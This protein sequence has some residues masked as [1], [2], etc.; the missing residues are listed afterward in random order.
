MKPF[1]HYFGQIR[2]TPLH[3]Q[4]RRLRWIVFPAVLILA[5]IHQSVLYLI[6]GAFPS[7]WQWWLQLLIYTLTGS[8]AAWLGLTWI[9]DAAAQRFETESQLRQAYA[10]LEQNHEKLLALHNLGERVASADDQHAILEIAARAPLELTAARASTV[11]TFDE[12]RDR[13]KLDMAWGLSE[14][15]LQALRNQLEIGIPAGR[16]QHCTGLKAHSESDCPLFRGLQST[17]RDEGIQSLICMPFTHDEERIGIISAYFPSADGPPEDQ[18]RLLNILGRV[19]ATALENLRAR[20]RELETVHALDRATNGSLLLDESPA[21]D[22]MAAQVLQI[23]VSGWD[24]QV[25]GLLLWEAET[26]TWDCITSLGFEVDS[27]DPCFSVALEMAQ[28][29]YQANHPVIRSGLGEATPAE[30]RSMAA[31]PLIIEGQ[32][33]GALFLGAWRRRAINE[34]QTE[35][36]NTIAHQI[37]LAIRNA[38]LYTQLG[39]LAVLKE[40]YRLSR[41]FHDGLAQTL[42]YLGF[43]ADRVENLVADDESDEA[44][45]EIHEL[46][47]TIRAA[48]ADV[49]EAIDGLRLS[50]EDPGQIA[51]RLESYTAAYARQTGINTEFRSEPPE[52]E[53]DPGTALQILRIAQEALTNVRKHAQASQVWVHLQE[54]QGLLQITIRDDGRGFPIELDADRAHHSYGLTT[55]RERAEGLGGTLTIAT[56][57]E[58]GTHI[59]VE[60]PIHKTSRKT[61]DRITS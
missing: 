5:A 7:S 8:L 49:R 16:C 12:A 52:L 31:V 21:L 18:V 22:Q 35:L 14:N 44:I 11:I 43:Q 50:V 36:L 6:A 33:L 40:R 4:L 47:Q 17:A 55:M 56:S 27:A 15:Y 42:G 51:M 48:Y 60:I 20:A 53:I 58:K 28:Q 38:Q 24:A 10:D 61:A 1:N 19:I 23:A 13:L 46:R 41:E 34:D 59:T 26:Q 37:A 29:A 32:T 2:N 54:E 45:A 39:H 3:F 30:L 9:A 57:P 25:G